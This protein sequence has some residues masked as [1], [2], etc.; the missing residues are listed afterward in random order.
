M[1][2]CF[3]ILT[4]L[5]LSVFLRQINARSLRRA[6]YVGR[7]MTHEFMTHEFMTHNFMAVGGTAFVTWLFRYARVILFS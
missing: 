4:A 2:I 3:L 5:S 7:P 1:R 6:V